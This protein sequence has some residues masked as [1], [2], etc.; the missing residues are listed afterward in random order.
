MGRLQSLDWTGGLDWWTGLVDWTGGLDTKNH[1]Y[2][3]LTSISRM[4]TTHM[5]QTVTLPSYRC[6]ESSRISFCLD[7][8]F[9]HRCCVATI[10]ASPP[11]S[12]HLTPESRMATSVGRSKSDPIYVSD[13]SPESSPMKVASNAASCRYV[14]FI[15]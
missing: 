14:S 12:A 13:S 3:F 15:W 10:G 6:P 4:R 9:S 5:P 11:S 1:F 8:S 2:A 7:G